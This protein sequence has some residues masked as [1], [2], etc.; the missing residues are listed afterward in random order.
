LGIGRL[1]RVAHVFERTTNSLSRVSPESFR[2]VGEV[3]VG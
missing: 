3:E 1:V 2:G